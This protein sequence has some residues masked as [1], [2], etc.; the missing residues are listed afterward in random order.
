MKTI[1]GIWKAQFIGVIDKREQGIGSGVAIFDKGRLLGGND[2]FYYDGFFDV[3]GDAISGEVEIKKHT[4]NDQSVF[5]LNDYTVI[6]SAEIED[7]QNLFLSAHVDKCPDFT[8]S[9]RLV[10]LKDLS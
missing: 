1:D 2:T 10:K 5:G 9:V 6:F 7:P 8:L 4:Q 3:K